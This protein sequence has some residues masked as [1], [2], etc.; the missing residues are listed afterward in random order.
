M[1]SKTPAVSVLL[2][3]C[4]PNRRTLDWV[5]DALAQQ[6]LPAFQFEIIV[7]DNNS[8][9]PLDEGA[10]K[11]DVFLDCGARFALYSVLC[12]AAAGSASV[13]ASP[14]SVQRGSLNDVAH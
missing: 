3:A 11:S 12:N 9:V 6:T 1:A 2:C 14:N 10:L 13:C 4:N 8:R 7:V 5:L